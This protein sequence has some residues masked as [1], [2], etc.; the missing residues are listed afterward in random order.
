MHRG[1]SVAGEPAKA[2]AGSVPPRRSHAGYPGRFETLPQ[3]VLIPHRLGAW[4]PPDRAVPAVPVRDAGAAGSDSGHP[5]TAD[6]GAE[7]DPRDA[8]PTDA[9]FDAGSPEDAGTETDT[10]DADIPDVDVPD[11]DSSDVDTPDAGF[12][13]DASAADADIPDGEFEDG[14]SAADADIPDGGLEDGSSE[15]DAGAPDSGADSGAPPDSE[16]PVGP[17]DDAP[18]MPCWVEVEPQP[19][20]AV[21]DK[22]AVRGFRSSETWAFLGVPYAAP[23]TR[24]LR[25]RDPVSHGCWTGVRDAATWSQ[26]CMQLDNQQNVVGDEDCL[27]LNVWTPAD[28]TPESRYPVMFW[29]HGGSNVVGSASDQLDDGTFMFDGTKLATKG[30]AVVVTIDYRLGVLGFLLHPELSAE[31]PR[32]SS[33]N[34]GTLDMIAALK[35]VKRN[36]AGFGGDPDHV[37][38]FGVSSGSIE[39]C[40][41][42]VSPAARGLFSSAIMQSGPCAANPFEVAT[43]A[44]RQFAEA[45]GCDAGGGV[46]G[47]LREAPAEELL[48]AAPSPTYDVTQLAV[49][50]YVIPEAPLAAIEAGRHNHV[51]MTI[52]VNS[53]EMGQAVGP[54]D[55]GEFAQRIQ[56]AYAGRL[57]GPDEVLSMYRISDYGDDARK[58]YVALL[59]DIWYICDGR[60]A[61]RAA[62]RGQEEPVFRYYFTHAFQAGGEEY[63]AQG[64]YHSA[65]VAY[66]FDYLALWWY[67]PTEGERA[68][69]D[70]M[71]GYWSRFAATGNPRGPDAPRWPRYTKRDDRYLR[72]DD[73]ISDGDGIRTTQCDFWDSYYF[74]SE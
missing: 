21:T 24:G 42:V 66:V 9:G 7:T 39:T 64:A 40:A 58:A 71:I 54:M 38:I 72:L 13:D 11:T 46:P 28:Y 16:C 68:L 15:G 43:L 69:S 65:E 23:P 50:G 59:S 61:A 4:P 34:Y 73:P 56:A 57:P 47:C 37:M 18:E 35:W 67:A 62:V 33:G 2:D 12:E 5:G 17:V 51:P 41:L 52:G 14:P 31:S 1:G 70:A 74:R 3:D 8:G 25:F 49:D 27:Y 19:G 63:A 26:K 45:L 22:G 6:A 48:L 44:G 32:C 36:I 29:I 10:S 20:L 55:E 53:E 60:R 30:R